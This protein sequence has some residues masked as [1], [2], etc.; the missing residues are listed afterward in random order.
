LGFETVVVLLGEK[1]DHG[2]EERHGHVKIFGP[3][4][5]FQR[6]VHDEVTGVS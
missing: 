3:E 5:R 2:E 1:L 6:L 4:T